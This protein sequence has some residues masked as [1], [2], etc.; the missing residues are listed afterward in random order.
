MFLRRSLILFSSILPLS[1]YALLVLRSRFPDAPHLT[2]FAA[3]SPTPTTALLVVGLASRWVSDAEEGL[4]RFGVQPLL[5]HGGVDV[6]FCTD[7][8]LE[9]DARSRL[10]G[11]PSRVLFWPLG[12]SNAFR[13][14][15]DC[16]A[17]I[18]DAIRGGTLPGRRA[19]EA[20]SFWVVTRPDLV[21]LSPLPPSSSLSSDM[22]HARIR[23][24]QGLGQEVNLTTD[25]FSWL[26]DDDRCVDGCAAPCRH[27]FAAPRVLIVCN[28][29]LLF[30]TG[31]VK[32]AFFLAEHSSLHLHAMDECYASLAPVGFWSWTLA[33]GETRFTCAMQRLNVRFSPLAVRAQLSALATSNV[34]NEMRWKKPPPVP[35][36]AKNC[37]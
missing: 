15:T 12:E 27:A 11:W 28:M 7:T 34:A 24:A 19:H 25:H 5:A 3:Q 9:D 32:D 31:P 36:I 6:H 21:L 17:A 10:A 22:L 14:A 20:Y 13:R 37:I 33:M 1:L 4:L 2:E 23:I 29:L 26:L 16:E 35:A 8:P 30:A 18:D